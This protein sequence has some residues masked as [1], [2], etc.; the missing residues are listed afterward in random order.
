MTAG[1]FLL[2]SRLRLRRGGWGNGYRDLLRSAQHAVSSVEIVYYTVY[3]VPIEEGEGWHGRP[4]DAFLQYF[5]K[6]GVSSPDGG[7]ILR[8]NGQILGLSAFAVGL[9]AMTEGTA[10]HID[11]FPVMI[12]DLQGGLIS[13]ECRLGIG[14]KPFFV[15][16][17]ISG[18]RLLQRKDPSILDQ[19][20]RQ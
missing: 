11:G 6:V 19:L 7:Q 18:Q 17:G 3:L 1:T 20:S 9:L 12:G 16:Q 13:V 4:V 14:F 5:I 15:V 8:R 10:I 2:I